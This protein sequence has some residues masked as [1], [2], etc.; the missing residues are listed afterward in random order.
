MSIGLTKSLSRLGGVFNLL[1][2]VAY[3]AAGGA[4]L[5]IPL[6][7]LRG[8]TEFATFFAATPA[9][10]V[11]LSL[12]LVALGLLGL[13]AV[14][15]ATAALLEER[16]NAWV[17]VGKNIAFLSLAVI[18]VYYAWFLSTIGAFV[19]AYQ[20]ATPELRSAIAVNDPRAPANWVAWFIFGG[21]GLW[22]VVVGAVGWTR[23]SLPR[24]FAVACAIKT[25]GF[26]I[27]LAGIVSDWITLA[28]V[29]VVVGVL[30]GGPLYHTWLGLIMLRIARSAP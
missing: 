28:Q 6:E 20:V 17:T 11:I 22:V 21:M 25:G 10:F 24:G 26:W 15:P 23:G 1:Q 9:P 8:T 7:R 27:A 30:I 29:G 19:S 3:L 12:A 13:T 18:V 5:F 2:S 16:H 4:A 14:V